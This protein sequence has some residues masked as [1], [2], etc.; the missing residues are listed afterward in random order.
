MKKNTN[1][2][3]NKNKTTDNNCNEFTIFLKKH[4]QKKLD[5]LPSFIDI[6]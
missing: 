5:K 4:Q 1:E 6:C 3:S 2:D